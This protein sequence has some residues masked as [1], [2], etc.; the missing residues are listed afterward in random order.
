MRLDPLLCL[1]ASKV[2]GLLE[3]GFLLRQAI[4]PIEVVMSNS[5]WHNL[6]DQDAYLPTL[7]WKV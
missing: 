3:K 1:L 5:G 4:L 7:A 2:V 6:I